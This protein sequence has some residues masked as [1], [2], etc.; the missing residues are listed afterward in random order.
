M[1][2]KTILITGAT[3][4]IGMELFEQYT[5]R[6]DNVIPCGRNATKLA[7]LADIAFQTCLFDTESDRMIT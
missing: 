3:S 4:G 5:T 1:T 6:G 2:A 7:L